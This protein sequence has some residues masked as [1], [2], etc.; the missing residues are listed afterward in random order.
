DLRLQ[1]GLILQKLNLPV[2]MWFS[3][4][5]FF[6]SASSPAIILSCCAC[7][8]IQSPQAPTQYTKAVD[9]GAW[10]KTPPCADCVAARPCAP[11]MPNFRRHLSVFCS[12]DFVL[13]VVVKGFH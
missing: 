2:K 11:S 1:S 8:L 12:F 5:P 7:V 9:G 4:L 13:I 6:C 10:R 3:E